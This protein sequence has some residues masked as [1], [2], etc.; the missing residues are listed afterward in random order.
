[1]RLERT[2]WDILE[3]QDPGC[4]KRRMDA[5]AVERSTRVYPNQKPWMTQEVWSLLKERDAAFRSGDG[6]QRS[7]AKPRRGIR[8]A[9]GKMECFGGRTKTKE[10]TGD[11]RRKRKRALSH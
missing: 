7:A 1:M 5:A 9:N 4:I 10:L 6:T 2:D 8:E 11:F 3:N